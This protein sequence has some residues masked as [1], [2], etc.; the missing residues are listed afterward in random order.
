MFIGQK[1]NS[2]FFADIDLIGLIPYFAY[3]LHHT[4]PTMNFVD[5]VTDILPSTKANLK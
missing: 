2:I 5:K 1:H 3:I 4:Q